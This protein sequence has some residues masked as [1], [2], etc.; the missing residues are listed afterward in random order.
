MTSSSLTL[1]ATGG[2]L[3]SCEVTLASYKT[4]DQ[5]VAYS[6]Q[7]QNQNLIPI[8]SLVQITLPSVF[9]I[10]SSSLQAVGI[11]GMT[12]TGLSVSYNSATGAI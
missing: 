8:G 5:N 7:F 6:F 12:T 10:T 9:V 11:L 2:I 4:S 3:S 1:T